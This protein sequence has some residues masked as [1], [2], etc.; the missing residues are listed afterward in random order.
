M[1]KHTANARLNLADCG[2]WWLA[3]P[4]FAHVHNTAQVPIKK[5]SEGAE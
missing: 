5:A 4:Q 1:T 3:K 2:K